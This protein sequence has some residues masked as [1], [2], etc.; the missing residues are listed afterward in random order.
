MKMKI[1]TSILTF[2]MVTLLFASCKKEIVTEGEPPKIN[3]DTVAVAP[4]KAETAKEEKLC[5]LKKDGNYSTAV[6]LV[7]IGE[8]VSGTIT[9]GENGVDGATGTLA[10]TKGANGEM[11]VIYTYEIEGSKQSE[12]KIM[13]IEN[14]TLMIKKGELI[15]PKNDGNMQYKDVAK[16]KFTQVLPSVTCK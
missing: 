13:K 6:N 3:A 10:G 4:A 12:N 1:T 9:A 8:Q 5:F 7:I 2:A 15:D 11:D 14:N 16:A